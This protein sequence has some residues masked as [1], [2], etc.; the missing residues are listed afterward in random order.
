[1]LNVL[2]LLNKQM[3][4]NNIEKLSHG[5][6]KSTWR[7]NCM[8]SACALKRHFQSTQCRLHFFAS[9]LLVFR[10]GEIW[11]CLDFVSRN[12][13]F[14][15]RFLVSLGSVPLLFT[16]TTQYRTART[17]NVNFWVKRKWIINHYLA[18]WAEILFY[19]GKGGGPLAP[20]LDSS[21]LGA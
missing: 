18:L 11:V 14:E 8:N 5:L 6:K 21:L 13:I 17:R 4:N 20:T 7:M 12:H 9:L 2:T 10:F 19:K 1:M 3:L 16:A 15:K